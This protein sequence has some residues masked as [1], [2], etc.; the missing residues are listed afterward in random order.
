MVANRRWTRLCQFAAVAD[1]PRNPDQ[2][3]ELKFYLLNALYLNL[4]PDNELKK[5]G[6]LVVGN[7]E[8]RNK[9]ECVPCALQLLHTNV[10]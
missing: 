4:L 7:A 5:I 6:F 9:N 2:R 1:S 3:P 8:V 10:R